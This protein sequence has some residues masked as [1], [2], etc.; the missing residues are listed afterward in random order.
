M[1]KHILSLLL[2]ALLLVAPGLAAAK[3]IVMIPGFQAQGM[4]WRFHQVTPMLQANGWVDGGNYTMTT[5]GVINEMKLS[6]RPTDVL[7]T[8]NLP[9]SAGIAT[10]AALL[11][12]YLKVIHQRRKEPL[13]LVGHSAGGV[14]ARHWLV[15]AARVP[16]E[17][18]ITIASPHTGTPL[19]G[20]TKMLL[21]NTDILNLANQL[22]FKHLAEAKALLTDLQA[23]RPG[24]YL[25]WLNH[26]PHPAIRYSAIVRS[27]GQAESANFIVPE[28]SQD[29]NYV[30][31]IKGRAE[32]WNSTD[33]HFLSAN[34]GHL[35]AAIMDYIPQ[36]A[37]NQ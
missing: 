13:T 9:T 23:E 32:R 12:N 6:R 7:F 15:T 4:D 34:D 24:N 11:N 36:G 10:Q 28:H 37:T 8:L 1:K 25:Y 35:L 17:A 21:S 31:A 16:V 18:L 30:Y 26:Q 20:L 2:P 27:G 14:V 29:M 33:S 3:T 19:A 22:G 5:A